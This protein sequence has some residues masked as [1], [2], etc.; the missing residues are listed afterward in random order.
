[1]NTLINKMGIIISL[2]FALTF[3]GTSCGGKETLGGQDETVENPDASGA[4][5]FSGGEEPSVA[6]TVLAP[7]P[8]KIKNEEAWNQLISEYGKVEQRNESSNVVKEQQIYPYG[9]EPP[10][11][12]VLYKELGLIDFLEDFIKLNLFF[13]YP[14]KHIPTFPQVK[15]YGDEYSFEELGYPIV[16]EFY[17]TAEG[18]SDRA[19]NIIYF[20]PIAGLPDQAS[21]VE[22]RPLLQR[23]KVYEALLNNDRF[24]PYFLDPVYNK[25][26]PY[27]EEMRDGL[28]RRIN[29]V[30]EERTNV[31]YSELNAISGTTRRADEYKLNLEPEEY[32]KI[33]AEIQ[34]LPLPEDLSD[35]YLQNISPLFSAT[36]SSF[37]QKVAAFNTIYTTN[38]AGLDPKE[39]EMID[40]FM[41]GARQVEQAMEKYV[42]T[43]NAIEKP[44]TYNSL[45]EAY[46]AV[47]LLSK[48]NYWEYKKM[49]SAILN[50]RRDY[51]YTQVMKKR[52]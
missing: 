10:P 25:L 41:V 28:L 32:N 15:K 48:E 24:Q 3:I 7:P 38:K 22:N 40:S 36:Q 43:I 30:L 27:K 6:G 46:F 2:A 21:V 44:Y 37:S 13:K 11:V 52:N 19:P 39:R 26:Y 5:N 12:R 34:D 29:N 9:Q 17:S 47:Q 45:M 49:A 14:D 33:I 42:S 23:K 16:R 4:L 50:E 51:Y 8:V 31:Y 18:P 35:Q 20:K 1:M